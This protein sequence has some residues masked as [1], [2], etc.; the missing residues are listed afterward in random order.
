MTENEKTYIG[1]II[2]T[3]HNT[4]IY[5]NTRKLEIVKYRSLFC[6]ILHKDLNYTLFTIRDYLNSRG[7]K[8]NHSSIIH[9][10]RLFEEFKKSNPDMLDTR[11]KILTK[12][13][14]KYLLLKRIK[15]IEDLDKIEQINNC[16]NSYE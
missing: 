9:N 6:Y 8:I 16:I 1:R 4:N 14:P 7:K 15:N 13:Y 2:N 3:I 10:I 5:E 11:D 12:I